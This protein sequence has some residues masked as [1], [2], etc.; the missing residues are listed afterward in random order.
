MNS[1][2]QPLASNSSSGDVG[3]LSISQQLQLRLRL[4]PAPTSAPAAALLE[5]ATLASAP[6]T[7]LG[8]G[9]LRPLS[10]R[11]QREAFL[12]TLGAAL[13]DALTSRDSTPLSCWK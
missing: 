11:T 10:H 2:S 8:S 12:N 6:P 3:V 1:S 5:Q 7:I 13:N 9:P 4:P